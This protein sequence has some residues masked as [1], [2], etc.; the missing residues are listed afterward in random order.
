MTEEPRFLS[1]ALHDEA[2]GMVRNG[3]DVDP[4]QQ[5]R[6]ILAIALDNREDLGSM[7]TRLK[8]IEEHPFHKITPKRLVA[9]ISGFLGLTLIYIKE[10]RDV[11]V[12]G[13]SAF[14]AIVL[15]T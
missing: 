12:D 11:I 9:M 10:S 5:R 14:V 1:K 2:I 15:G 13:I 6:I 8:R 4:N 7:D 3:D